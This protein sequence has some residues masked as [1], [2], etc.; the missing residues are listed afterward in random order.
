MQSKLDERDTAILKL[1][2]EN[3]KFSSR[4]IA[5]K[6]DSPITTVFTKIK[7]MEKLG[8]IKGYKAVLNA[9]A[10]GQGTT[11]FILASI[12]YQDLETDAPLSQRDVARQISRF[13]EVQE[14]H[15]ISGN[16]DILMKV[17]VKDVDA[18][19]EFV[20][21]KLRLVKGIEKTLTCMVFGTVKESSEI[22]LEDL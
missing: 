18:V 19:G 16:W 1:L 5:S 6:V 10:L 15:I 4:E 2:Q 3:C 14:V 9:R 12:T 11:A 17:K 8:F 20:I 22:A 7:R 21:D 13:R